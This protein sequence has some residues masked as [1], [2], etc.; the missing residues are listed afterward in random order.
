[1]SSSTAFFR[2]AK[3]VKKIAEIR[4]FLKLFKNRISMKSTLN[5]GANGLVT[6]LTLNFQTNFMIF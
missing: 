3:N 1:M 4:E 2:A 5:I 6:A